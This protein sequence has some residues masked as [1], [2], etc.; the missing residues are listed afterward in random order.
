MLVSAERLAEERVLVL[1]R[2]VEA[3]TAD[4]HMGA[5][6]SN[7]GRL[8]SLRPEEIHRLVERFITL[9]L[10]GSTYHAKKI[11]LWADLSRTGVLGVLDTRER[12][13]GIEPGVLSLLVD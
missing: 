5:Q 11:P 2:V 3:L 1:E 7:T 6:L 12:D 8:V 10:S 9:E 13:H 4:P